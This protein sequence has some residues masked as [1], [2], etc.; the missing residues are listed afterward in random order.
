MK[1]NFLCNPVF[2]GWEPTDTR[3]G[4]TEESIV[5]WAGELA[6]RGHEV[7]V[8]RNGSY[9][10]FDHEVLYQPRE[11]YDGSGDICINLKSSEVSPKEPTLYLTNETDATSKD[12]SAYAGVIWPS[13]YALESIPV[14]NPVKYVLPHGYDNHHIYPVTKI[15]NQC[16]YASSPD[17]G[18]QT[19][20]KLWPSI[21]AEHPDATL[22]VTYGAEEFDC[23]GVEFLGDV[24][25]E[26][27]NRLY[28]ESD[29]WAYPCNG[30]ELF[31][32]TGIKAQAAGC[33]P[34]I[35]PTMALKET[36][37]HGFFANED[38]FADMLRMALRNNQGKK[39]MV[40]GKLAQ[41]HYV[42]WEESTDRLIEII[43]DTLKT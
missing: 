3:L 17:R 34:V 37:R 8:Y 21:Y 35:I 36:V 12:L 2:D 6:K 29:I 26:T 1:I 20:L 19:L 41:E 27:M 23:P 31:G 24:D 42:N 10:M 11:E 15:T 7:N 39:D 22:K 25:E 16:L 28:R 32:I 43:N 30:G 38:T 14:N 4:G 5:K 9:H 40:R 13:E 33:V 18:L